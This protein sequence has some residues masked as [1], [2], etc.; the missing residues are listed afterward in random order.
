MV[1]YDSILRND[2]NHVIPITVTIKCRN[3]K[4]KP[5]QSL[6]AVIKRDLN[7]Q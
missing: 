5:I 2:Q 4:N 1:Q 3:E 7:F 6:I